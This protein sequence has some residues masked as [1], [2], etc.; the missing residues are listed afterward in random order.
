M[1]TPQGGR[2]AKDE[3]GLL[4]KDGVVAGLVFPGRTASP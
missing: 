2:G 1:E 4:Q 3:E